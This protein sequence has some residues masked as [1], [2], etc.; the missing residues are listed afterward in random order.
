MVVKGFISLQSI[1]Y[2]I[3]LDPWSPCVGDVRIMTYDFYNTYPSDH[4]HWDD[5]Y[6]VTYTG[7]N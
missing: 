1:K 5:Y 7:G 3:V 6:D 4:T 2:V